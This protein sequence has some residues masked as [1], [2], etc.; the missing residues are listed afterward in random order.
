M[1]LKDTETTILDLDWDKIDTITKNVKPKEFYVEETFFFPTDRNKTEDKSTKMYAQKTEIMQWHSKDFP[2]VKECIPKKYF[3]KFGIEYSNGVV[4]INGMR[5]G[6]FSHPH[7]D[8]YNGFK[9]KA[10]PDKKIQK[11]K[12]VWVCVTNHL[13]HAFFLD[14]ERV[15]YNLP[16]GT[17]FE[18]HGSSMHSGCNAGI[19]DRYW[20]SFE[21]E[22]IHG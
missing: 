20:M 11:V 3:D 18:W 1:S 10:N 8:R 13:G 19:T 14:R 12:R 17:A 4:K 22:P 9:Q 2:E 5:P 16:K 15:A 7:I 21:G 6:N